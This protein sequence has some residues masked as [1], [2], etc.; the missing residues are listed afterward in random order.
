MIVLSLQ[1]ASTNKRIKLMRPQATDEKEDTKNLDNRGQRSVAH[2]EIELHYF[3]QVIFYAPEIDL[4]R[5]VFVLS[6]IL[7]SSLTLKLANNF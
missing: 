1:T 4:G 5:I 6:V 2:S 3:L 7:S